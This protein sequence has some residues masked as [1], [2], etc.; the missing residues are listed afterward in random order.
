MMNNVSRLVNAANGVTIT[1]TYTY[2]KDNLITRHDMNTLRKH[3]Y[4]PTE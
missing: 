1:P 2:G 4:S 3:T